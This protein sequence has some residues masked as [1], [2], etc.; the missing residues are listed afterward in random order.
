MENIK[1]RKIITTIIYPLSL[2][3]LMLSASSCAP[4]FD[5]GPTNPKVAIQVFI[6][7]VH[8]AGPKKLCGIMLFPKIPQRDMTLLS[9]QRWQRAYANIIQECLLQ[10]RAFFVV[11]MAPQTSMT[12][13]EA[14]N[15]A[16]RWHL[17]CVIVPEIPVILPP[18]DTATGI[19]ALKL[20]V[21]NVRSEETI[22]S[23]YAQAQLV[24]QLHKDFILWQQ[25]FRQAPSITQALSTL[26]RDIALIIR[27]RDND[28]ASNQFPHYT[29]QYFLAANQA[30]NPYS[31][32]TANRLCIHNTCTLN[33][34]YH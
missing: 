2:I 32:L 16:R 11:E 9:V 24:P 20:K 19:V 8:Y 7:P 30:Y 25:N 18:T 4:L 27:D 28:V 6:K 15:Q 29:N 17:N 3:T 10:N 1:F 21:I 23:I 33:Q 31:A 12:L 14:G 5:T 26:T 22:W 34:T 13:K